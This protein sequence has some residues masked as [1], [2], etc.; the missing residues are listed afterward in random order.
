M[1]KKIAYIGIPYSH[2]DPEVRERRFEI[3]CDIAG[4]LI[5]KGEIIYSPISHAHSIAKKKKLP[6]D[7]EYWEKNDRAF[8][9]QC[10]RLYVVTIDGW[11][12]SV[13]LQ[14]EIKIAEELGLEIIYLDYFEQ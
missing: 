5:N 10:Y 2:N 4:D 3:A 13:G 7:W 12:D 9:E 8:L 14:A 11:K 6:V 1:D